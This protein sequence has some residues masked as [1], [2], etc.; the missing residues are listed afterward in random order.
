MNIRFLESF[1][2]VSRLKSFRAAAEKLNVSQATISSR[3]STLETELQ[4]RLFDR[5]RN[6]VVLTTQGVHLLPR[7]LKVLA[8]ETE[9]KESLKVAQEPAGRV[10]I[11]VIESI[12]HTWLS[13]FLSQIAEIFPKVEIELTAEP[14]TILHSLFAKGGLDLIIQTD[15]VLEESVVNTPLNPLKLGWVCGDDHPLGQ[16]LVTLEKLAEY[17]IVTFARGS[18]PHLA[19][20]NMFQEAELINK[21]IHCVTSLAAIS[22]FVRN[23]GGVASMPVSPFNRNPLNQGLRVIKTEATPPYLDLVASWHRESSSSAIQD[24]VEIAKTVSSNYDD[25]TVHTDQ[26][27]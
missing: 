11:G 3:I 1:V 16:E 27:S 17:Q 25:N 9:L 18:R 2:W 8:A 26:I 24:L 22:V 10:R 15:A 21:Q 19:I 4:C 14:T 20:L 12:V 23:V 5:D 13:P 7:A 6:E